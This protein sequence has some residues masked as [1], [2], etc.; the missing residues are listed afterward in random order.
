MTAC[1]KQLFGLGDVAVKGAV[2]L[3]PNLTDPQNFVDKVG[4]QACPG[5]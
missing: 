5:Y 1:L 4:R 2:I 3:H